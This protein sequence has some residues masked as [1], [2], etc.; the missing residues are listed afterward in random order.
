M[1]IL[2]KN[3]DQYIQTF[4]LKWY[5]KNK[6][7]LPWRNLGSNNRTNAY[8]VLVSEFMLQQTTVNTVT[9]RFNEF[10]KLW[11]SIDKLSKISENRILRFWSGLGYYNRAK[12]L[13]K[14]IKIIS[15]DFK[16]KV[17]QH[18]DRL[19]ELPGVGDYTAKAILGIAYNH[20]VL[21]L[22]ANIKRI[23]AR[24]YGMKTLLRLNKK[25]I[26]DIA[27][28]YQSLNKASDLIQSFMDY[29]SAICLP[30]NPKCDEC[31]IEKFCEARKKNIQH[32][33]PFKNLSLEKKKI[34]FT[35]A[36]IVVNNINE[37]LVNRRKSSG[38]LASMLEVPNDQWVN[39]KKLL[40]R[41]AIY[42]KVGNKFKYKRAFTYS[43]SHFDLDID[44]YKT[45]VKKK[46]FKDHKWMK[47][48]Q[49]HISG[50]PTVMKQ[51]IKKS[52]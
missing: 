49:I 33:I 45:V 24:L 48:N 10:I 41:N 21:P 25:K 37:I 11:P 5:E 13:L 26:E 39:K 32:L 29:G 28:Q 7:K 50:M 17:P 12:N 43:F 2:N 38:M 27:S 30:R 42:E 46:M 40:E 35:R 44:I 47:T 3:K 16:S 23:I 52:R 51:I 6:R 20:P 34:K 18:Y 9:K 1:P 19:I 22:D 8:Y 14:T 31:L 36:Y 15:R 4:L